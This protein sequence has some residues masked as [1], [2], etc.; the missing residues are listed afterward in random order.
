MKFT[1]LSLFP[2]IFQSPFSQSI[3]KR[4]QQS[5]LL[6]VNIVNP[7][8][9]SENKHKTVDDCPYGGGNGMVI[10]ADVIINAIRNVCKQHPAKPH[11]V[12]LSPGG[13]AFTQRKAESLAGLE[14][15][16][17]IC[18][19][20]E[21]IDE[22]V[23]TIVDEC[24]SIGDYVLTGGEIPAMVIIDAVA[25]LIPGVLGCSESVVNESFSLQLLEHPQYTRPR[26]VSGLEVPNVLLSG[27]HAAI[28]RWR[29]KESLRKTLLTR[30]DLLRNA[31][32]EA[33]D[34]VLLAEILDEL[35]DQSE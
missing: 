34:G 23:Q 11:V 35:G 5:G 16:L 30:P 28:D 3:L 8:I 32:L 25:R 10:R 33:D 20:Y 14:H 7:R 21:G 9:Y 18:G 27:N 29:R 19:H 24:I 15:L 13:T 2:E 4:A 26:V 22:R 6:E 12:L 17:L 1:I 31:Q